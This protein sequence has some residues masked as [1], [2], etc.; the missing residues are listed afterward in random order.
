MPVKLEDVTSRIGQGVRTSANE[1]Y[2]LNL[3]SNDG[4]VITAYSKQLGKTVALERQSVLLFLQGRE[5]KPYELLP[6]GKVV[7]FPYRINGGKVHLLTEDELTMNYPKA[8]EYL[9]SNQRYLSDREKGRFRGVGW[10]GYGRVQNIDL[11]LLSKILVPDIADRSSFALDE[12]GSYAFTSGYGITLRNAV[13]ESPKYILGLL[14]SNALDF[15]LKR[16]STPLRG[17][18]F[19]YFTQFVEQL[20]IRT[21][22][23]SNP[24]DKSRHD[25]VVELVEQMLSLHKRLANARIPRDKTILQ[26]LIDATDRQIDRVVYELYGLTEEEIRMVEGKVQE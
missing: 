9:R 3:V 26:Q 23:F 19:R 25:R 16:V 11:M 20:P 21:I 22:N 12:N 14:N 24:T 7:L 1:V 8:F 2:V 18:F 10:Y 6:S 15:F 17:G 5:I 4:D 13:A